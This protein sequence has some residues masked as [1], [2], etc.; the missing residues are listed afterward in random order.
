MFWSFIYVLKSMVQEIKPRRL[1]DFSIDYLELDW[2]WGQR[3]ECWIHIKTTQNLLSNLHGWNWKKNQ[4]FVVTF[5]C[6]NC[7]CRV[8]NVQNK[9]PICWEN[10]ILRMCTA[11]TFSLILDK[12]LCF[13]SSACAKHPQ[14]VVKLCSTNI[15]S[16]F[17][18]NFYVS[19]DM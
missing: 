5:F 9:C 15:S 6:Q 3:C 18:F 4:L 11:C 10:L 8:L 2:K 14:H 16:C 19:K 1:L 13:H 17:N 12:H 7:I